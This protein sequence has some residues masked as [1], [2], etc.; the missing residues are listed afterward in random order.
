SR[1]FRSTLEL[2]WCSHQQRLSTFFFSSR[3]RHTRSK[4]DW[5][6]DVCSSDLLQFA[7]PAHWNVQLP[8]GS[9]RSQLL[10]RGLFL[11]GHHSGPSEI[12]RASCRERVG[13]AVAGGV[14][15]R[16]AGPGLA[17]GT[18]LGGGGLERW[19]GRS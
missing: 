5:S 6:S 2:P 10:H 12:G 9:H 17:R 18:V 16:G 1:S 8:G 4:R 19:G 3:R 14:V 7:D 15:G 13:V 11:I